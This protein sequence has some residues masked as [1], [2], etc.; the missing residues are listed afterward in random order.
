M[1][2]DFLGLGKEPPGQSWKIR[3]FGP[4]LLESARLLGSSVVN[5]HPGFWS[6]SFVPLTF[7]GRC[8]P[9]LR[10]SCVSIFQDL[11]SSKHCQVKTRGVAQW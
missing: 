1:K 2:T 9:I 10:L 11:K 6:G 8:L 3:L 7:Y 5:Y 4:W